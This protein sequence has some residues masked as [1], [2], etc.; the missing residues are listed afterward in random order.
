MK[1]KA[2]T[3]ERT[4]R[5]KL[6][7]NFLLWALL[8]VISPLFPKTTPF[9]LL[10]FFFVF[11]PL[12]PFYSTLHYLLFPFLLLSS[13]LSFSSHPSLHLFPSFHLFPPTLLFFSSCSCLL[14]FFSSSA[15]LNATLPSSVCLS[16][17]VCLSVCLF[18][19]ESV[20]SSSTNHIFGR[21]LTI[22][23]SLN[24]ES[25]AVHF[26]A[27]FASFLKSAKIKK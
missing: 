9:L 1:V 14:F 8:F 10:F 12:L 3:R 27:N 11:S 20:S 19:R 4:R 25:I 6:L 24:F 7:L 18:V 26:A 5:E 17:C 23:N 2:D 16:F 22:I 13:P 15:A 21:R